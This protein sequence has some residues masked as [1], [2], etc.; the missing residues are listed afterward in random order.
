MVVQKLADFAHDFARSVRRAGL[1]ARA[2]VLA[3]AH[4]VVEI[5]G[6]LALKDL[7]EAR[8]KGRANIGGQAEGVGQARAKVDVL[9]L[10]EALHEVLERL[11]L[12]AGHALGADFFF[13][14][15]DAD[16]GLFGAL[17]V[18]NRGKLCVR[19]DSVIVAVSTDHA[20]V[21]AD[22]TRVGSRDG[23]KL[24]GDE[25]LFHDAVFFVQDPENRQLHAVLAVI[26]CL[27]AAAHQNVQTLGRNGFIEGLFA[28]FAPQMGKK[29]GD[30][31]LRVRGVVSDGHVDLRAVAADDLSVQL[32]RNRYPLVLADAA[33]MVRLEVGK[34][35][36]LIKG[37]GLDVESRCVGVCRA[38]VRAVGQIFLADDRQHD[39]L[40]AVVPIELVAGFDLYA[41]LVFDKASG[42]CLA[43]GGK[44]AFALGLRA[45]QKRLVRLAIGIQLGLFVLC[46]AVIAIFRLVEKLL[47]LFLRHR[48]S[49]FKISFSRRR[50]FSRNASRVCVFSSVYRQFAR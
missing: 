17:R 5:G 42:L 11:A 23:L 43:D 8:V 3:K 29:V 25:V 24:R 46:Q 41:G 7:G 12:H 37:I 49:S 30:D 44:D 45:V 4:T 28:L 27:G 13:V 35:G 19:A 38:D 10:A 48:G 14:G 40:A 22:I 18:E 2:R 31:E 47:S 36:V 6:V 15:K 26:V 32:Q 39:G 34:L 50:A 21:Q 1:A 20:A 16:S 33:V 9:G